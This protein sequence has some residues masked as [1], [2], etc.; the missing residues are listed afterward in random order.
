MLLVTLHGGS[1]GDTNVLA[2]DTDT[3]QLLTDSLLSAPP[4]NDLDELRSMVLANGYLYVANGGTT[5][6]SVL[7]YRLATSGASAA[8]VSTLLSCSL[9]DGKDFTTAIAH[10]F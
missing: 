6:S 3:H 7:C 10:P 2:F 4:Q 8:Y 5:S 1:G 9:V